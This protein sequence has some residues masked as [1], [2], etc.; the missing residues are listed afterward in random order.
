MAEQTKIQWAD[1]TWS[2]W[3]G[4]SHAVLPDGTEHP[5]C[6]NCYAE[7]QAKRNPRI[8]GTWGQDGARVVNS[9]WTTPEH[10]EQVARLNDKRRFIFPSLCDPFEDFYGH[11]LTTGGEV[12]VDCGDCGH[13]GPPAASN[14]LP[15]HCAQCGSGNVECGPLDGTRLRFFRLIDAT[16]NL[17]WLL[18][19]KRPQNVRAMFLPWLRDRSGAGKESPD[20]A[21]R[22]MM[23][24]RNVWLGVSVSDQASADGLIPELLQ[25]RDLLPVLFVSCEPLL[26]PIDLDVAGEGVHALGCGNDNH[27]H[28]TECA[29]IDWLIVGGESGPRSRP[30]NVAWVR[31]LVEQCQEAEVPCFVKQLG[32]HVALDEYRRLYLGD[33]K[34]GDQNEWPED[35]R[36]QE[37]PT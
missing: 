14:F 25:L 28:L 33:P 3:R 31:S 36:V 37:V 8:M 7:R 4:C 24:L 5:G 15:P 32:A 13:S 17:T 27:R 16:P 1:S 18:L 23:P 21:W 10:Y 30:C 26:G 35:L 29:S 19:T 34:G 22:T 2:P 6:Q 20:D 11:V 9:S 12:V